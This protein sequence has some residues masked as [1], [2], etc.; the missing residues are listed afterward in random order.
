MH[1]S[2]EYEQV[3]NS[4]VSLPAHQLLAMFAAMSRRM[5]GL[6]PSMRVPLK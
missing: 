6:M 5:V 3:E 4:L 2:D 1:D